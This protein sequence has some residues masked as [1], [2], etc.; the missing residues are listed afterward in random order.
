MN[1]RLSSVHALSKQ[2]S[3]GR[4]MG[5]FLRFTGSV[6]DLDLC[7][8]LQSVLNDLSLGTGV[9]FFEDR[10]V[11]KYRHQKS[12][13]LWTLG[14]EIDPSRKSDRDNVRFSSLSVERIALNT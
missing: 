11:G 5:E 4:P 8:F 3:G 10:V 14:R 13:Y 1:H 9:L 7:S 2:L 12:E 6:D